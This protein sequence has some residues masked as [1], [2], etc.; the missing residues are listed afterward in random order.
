MLVEE[1]VVE[2]KEEDLQTQTQEEVICCIFSVNLLVRTSFAALK[3]INT[4]SH[5]Y[6]SD[7][8]QIKVLFRT[9]TITS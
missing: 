9:G 1:K 8:N 4:Y 2:D 7:S 5:S 6:S 3:S